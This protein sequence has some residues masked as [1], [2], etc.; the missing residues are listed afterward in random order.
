MEN[1]R[2]SQTRET[3]LEQVSSVLMLIAF[4]DLRGLIYHEF[5]PQEQTVNQHYYCEVLKPLIQKSSA[6]TMGNQR[7]APSRFHWPGRCWRF[8]LEALTFGLWI[9]SSAN[10]RMES[11]RSPR[12]I[13]RTRAISRCFHRTR[14]PASY[15]A[16]KFRI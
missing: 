3:T 13:S 10:M 1:A 8:P 15:K 6:R 9:N 16:F 7:L 5:V 12:I 11:R 2:I 4:F 14:S